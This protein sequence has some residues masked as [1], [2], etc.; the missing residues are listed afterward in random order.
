MRLLFI[1]LFSFS[2]MAETEVVENDQTIPWPGRKVALEWLAD[3]NEACNKGDS[4]NEGSVS[5][6]FLSPGGAYLIECAFRSAVLAICLTE[7]ELSNGQIFCSEDELLEIHSALNEAIDLQ[8]NSDD[9]SA[10]SFS[11]FRNFLAQSDPDELLEIHRLLSEDLEPEQYS[12][13]SETTRRY[14]QE[15]HSLLDGACNSSHSSACP[16]KTAVEKLCS[17]AGFSQNCSLKNPKTNPGPP[18]QAS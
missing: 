5:E 14:F 4:M 2:A 18:L 17:T 6:G 8:I 13:F 11:D 15:L 3:R 9:S 16:R 10:S 12:F 1:I 7:D